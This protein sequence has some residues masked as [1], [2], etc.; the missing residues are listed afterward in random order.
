VIKRYGNRRLY[1][2][3]LSR[4]VTM[5]EIADLVRKGEDVRVI[6]GD[7]GEDLTK[8]VLTQIIL[9]QSNARVLELLPVEFLRRLINVRSDAASEWLVQYLTMGAQFLEKQMEVTGPAARLMQDSLASMFPWMQNW[10]MERD[11]PPNDGEEASRDDQIRAQVE[12]LQRRLADLTAQV[13]GR[14]ARR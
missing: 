9:E 4:C 1:D 11:A 5:D 14:S 10:I 2:G 6:D 8:R 12:E 7:S 13:G 3:Q